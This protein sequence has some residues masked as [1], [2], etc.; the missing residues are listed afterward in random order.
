MWSSLTVLVTRGAAN[1]I[2]EIVTT[3]TDTTST[4]TAMEVITTTFAILKGWRLILLLYTVYFSIRHAVVK[5][6][7]IVFSILIDACT[8]ILLIFVLFRL[9]VQSSITTNKLIY[10]FLLILLRVLKMIW[11]RMRQTLVVH[12]TI[13]LLVGSTRARWFFLLLNYRLIMRSWSS[14]RWIIIFKVDWVR[15][16][17]SWKDGRFWERWYEYWRGLHHSYHCH[18]SEE[19]TPVGNRRFKSLVCSSHLFW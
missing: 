10:S 14:F 9:L 8:C 11:G 18:G 16:F 1:I 4:S 3:T 7:V 15:P 6:V 2:L 17:R 13:E 12:S 5:P 19:A